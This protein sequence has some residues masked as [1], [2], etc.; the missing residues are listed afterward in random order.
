MMRMLRQMQILPFRY[1][2]EM[3][4]C[5]S[6]PITGNLNVGMIPYGKNPYMTIL[7][8]RNIQILSEVITLKII[9]R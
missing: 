1:L 9:L 5:W 2:K 7:Y 4:I 8:G 3:K 6:L